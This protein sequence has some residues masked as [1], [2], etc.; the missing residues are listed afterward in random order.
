MDDNVL[1]INKERV[2]RTIRALDENNMN[3]YL[4]SSKE[5]ANRKN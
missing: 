2:L 1:W 3:G 4:V 5:E